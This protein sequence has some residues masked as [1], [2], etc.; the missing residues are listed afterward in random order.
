M[1][2]VNKS[3]L[4]GCDASEIIR[5]PE[6]S[7][8]DQNECCDVE[9]PSKNLATTRLPANTSFSSQVTPPQTEPLSVRINTLLSGKMHAVF[10]SDSMKSSSSTKIDRQ[11][12]ILE[13]GGL[14]D[15]ASEKALC[16]ELGLDAD[17]CENIIQETEYQLETH[18]IH[19]NI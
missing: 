2:D 12:L 13:A 6:S 9:E 1:L 3:N 15:R 19:Q 17:F 7:S 18:H 10:P 5:L 14:L 8:P 16:A 11:L 4:P